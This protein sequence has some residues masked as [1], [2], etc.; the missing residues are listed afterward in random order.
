MA[1]DGLEY[2]TLI[3]RSNNR[4]DRIHQLQLLPFHIVGE[5]A[6]CI[7][8]EFKESAVESLGEHASNDFLIKSIC[9]GVI[10]LSCL[11]QPGDQPVLAKT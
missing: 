9:S 1:D 2:F 10:E 7:G 6:S 3:E 4:G 11:Y 8:R 5:K